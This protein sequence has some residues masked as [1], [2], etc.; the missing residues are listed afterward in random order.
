VLFEYQ[1]PG[2]LTLFGRMTGIRYY[3]PG[4]GARVRVD[5]RDAPSL[6]IIRGLDIAQADGQEP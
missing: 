3:F 1:G 6:E 2:S 5:G 4:P